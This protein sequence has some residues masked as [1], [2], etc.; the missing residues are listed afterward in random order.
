MRVNESGVYIFDLLS[1]VDLAEVYKS[2]F[3]LSLY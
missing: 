2:L 1:R 3:L